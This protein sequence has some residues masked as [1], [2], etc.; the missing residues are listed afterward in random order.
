MMR[1]LG[2]AAVYALAACVIGYF[3]AAPTY[4][5]FPPDRALLKLSFSHGAPRSTECRRLSAEEQAK[6][7]PNMRRTVACPRVRPAVLVEL[8]VDGTLLLAEWLPPSGLSGDGPSRIYHRFMVTP[9]PHLVDAR[10]RDTARQEGFDYQRQ[11]EVVLAA[12]QSVAIDF[13]PEGGG[14]IF[15]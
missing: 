8:S 11:G 6:T 12:G 10:L 13:R 5:H 7:A 3:S 15:R 9:G 4:T 2:Q 1:H 14:F